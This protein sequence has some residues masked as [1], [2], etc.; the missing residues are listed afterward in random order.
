[1]NSLAPRRASFGG[2][3][4]NSALLM[5]RRAFL[6]ASAGAA[7]FR[8]ANAVAAVRPLRILVL[9]G[10]LFLGPPF[11][12]AALAQGHHVTLF[13]RGMTNPELFPDVEKL[14]GFRSADPEDENLS[15]LGRRHWD[16]V[17]DVWP[18]DPSL[19]ESAAIRLADRTQHYVYVSSIGAYDRSA[20]GR[21]NVTED[22]PL[23]PWHSDQRPY[24]RGKAESER[25]LN[26]ILGERL[27]VVRPGAIKGRRDDTP[28]AFFWLKRMIAR[29][30]VVA[31]G[32]GTSPVQI[33]DVR[34]V[35]DFMLTAAEHRLKGPFNAT[36]PQI[37][38]RAFLEAC[39]SATHSDAKLIWVPQSFLERQGE[40]NFSRDYP[41]F[42]PPNDLSNFYRVNNRRAVLAGL[43]TRDLRDTLQESL[44]WFAAL[45]SLQLSDPM[46]SNAQ[47][48]ILN[49]WL[50]RTDP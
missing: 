43:H 48:Q 23:A 8:P 47:D 21:P 49:A 6:K 5:Q 27:T 50:G 16:V 41:Y 30:K 11:I 44:S 13:N 29:D 4:P 15:S 35:A 42:T 20:W 3:D 34:D 37:S 9:G 26:A 10:T 24:N 22:A 2:R 28:D 31:P 46:S 25:R 7:L 32:D 19:A 14:R 40:S 18:N 36:G 39:A 33:I 1:V 45:P 38:F 17:V 12:E